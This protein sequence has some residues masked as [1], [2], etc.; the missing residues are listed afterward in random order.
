[1]SHLLLHG[2]G[3]ERNDY[4]AVYFSQNGHSFVT[5][6]THQPSPKAATAHQFSPHTTVSA[7]VRHVKEDHRSGAAATSST[8][9]RGRVQRRSKSPG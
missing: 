6:K 8:V 4:L 1:M 7:F 5:N 9:L 2:P 3:F